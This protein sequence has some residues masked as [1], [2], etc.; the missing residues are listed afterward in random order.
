MA[1]QGA[2]CLA[3]RAAPVRSGPVDVDESDVV[4][5]VVSYLS[6]SQLDCDGNEKP[7]T[8]LKS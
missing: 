8:R 5:H 2:G 6:C 3:Q 7:L 4:R 1:V